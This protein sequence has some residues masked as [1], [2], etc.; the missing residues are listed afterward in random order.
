[1]T[2]YRMETYCVAI[3]TANF[4]DVLVNNSLLDMHCKL[5]LI[6][7]ARKMFNRMPQRNFVSWAAIIFGY[8]ADKNGIDHFEF[9]RLMLV[10]DECSV[11]ELMFEFMGRQIHGFEFLEMGRQVYGFEYY[12][13]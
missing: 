11:D 9:F 12:L 3:K 4:A 1:M 13:C 2:R 5:E 10:E 7:D 6:F 8:V